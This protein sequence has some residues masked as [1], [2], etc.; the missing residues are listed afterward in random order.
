MKK[1][2][3]GGEGERE[4][5]MQFIQDFGQ[6]STKPQWEKE[7]AVSMVFRN[8]FINQIHFNFWM[9]RLCRSHLSLFVSPFF[10]K[11][12]PVFMEMG[13]M[14]HLTS[15]SLA[16]CNGKAPIERHLEEQDIYFWLQL[17]RWKCL[18]NR[19]LRL[20]PHGESREW[21]RVSGL[22]EISLALRC[23]RDLTESNFFPSLTWEK[24]NPMKNCIGFISYKLI[25]QNLFMPFLCFIFLH[26]KIL[27]CQASKKNQGRNYFI[28]RFCRFIWL[29]CSSVMTFICW[30]QSQ[31]MLLSLYADTRK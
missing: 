31:L 15:K 3:C 27:L 25:S 19:C 16:A 8:H 21:G 10:K 13:N 26:A 14:A 22:S 7:D 24:K 29:P 9:P 23:S 1:A 2:G 12:S 18:V 4:R 5:L 28:K 20:P 30:S 6:C 17:R 11:E